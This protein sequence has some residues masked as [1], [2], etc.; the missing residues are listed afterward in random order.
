MSLED[1]L[2]CYGIT[3]SLDPVSC[4]EPDG[5][6]RPKSG[7]YQSRF[8]IDERPGKSSRTYV[9]QAAW[10]LKSGRWPEPGEEVRHL[11]GNGHLGCSNPHHLDIGNRQDNVNDAKRHGSYRT[12]RSNWRTKLSDEDVRRVR[13]LRE[14]G[15]L[16]REIAV[17]V[18]CSPS[19]V[20][21]ILNGSARDSVE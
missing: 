9:H 12:G 10:A 3:M 13:N 2:A 16:Q 7:Y 5:L 17:L 6:K 18:G 21:R 1:A 4:V 11:C 15:M 8:P 14:Q 20:G 19:H